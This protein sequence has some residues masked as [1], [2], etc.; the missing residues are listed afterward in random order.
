LTDAEIDQLKATDLV[1]ELH[2]LM[3]YKHRIMYYGPQADADFKTSIAKLH[4]L[5]ASFKDYPAKVNFTPAVQTTNQL[6]FTNYDMVQSEIAWIRN[7]VGYDAN[8]EVV[9]NVFNNYFGGGMGSVVFQTIRESKALAYSTFASYNTPSKKEN[10]FY[11]M[12]YVGCQADKMN[13]AIKGMNEL[14][15]ELPASEQRFELARTGF[16]KDLETE[17]ITKEDIIDAYLKAQQKGWKGDFRKDEYAALS[18]LKLEDVQKMHK[19]QISGKPFTY[20]V[21]ASDKKIR[22][23]DLKTIGEVKTVSLEELFGY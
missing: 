19:E 10:P 18:A 2:S 15:T 13:E 1:N 11:M 6:L 3:Q 22:L 12:A 20:C 17:R 9:V 21:V 16:K 14:L 8:K 5:P 23:D 4:T 7:D